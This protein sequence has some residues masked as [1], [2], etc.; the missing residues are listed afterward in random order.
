VVSL[1][2]NLSLLALTFLAVHICAA[3]IDPYAG[4]RWADVLIPF[5]SV[6][7]PFWLGLGAVC[8]DLVI[9]VV[10]TSMLRHRMPL[11]LWRVLHWAGYGVYPVAVVHGL[12]IGGPDSRLN[13]VLACVVGCVLAVGT[14][15]WWRARR[16]HPDALARKAAEAELWR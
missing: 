13:W 7:Q 1:H 9:A 10:V 5:V 3:V 11:K 4:I 6:Y 15:V 12:G 16:D 14:A 2:R 8:I